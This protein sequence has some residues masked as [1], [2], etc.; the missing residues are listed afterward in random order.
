MNT[1]NLTLFTASNERRVT[2][3]SPVS[4]Y[5]AGRRWRKSSY[6]IEIQSLRTGKWISDRLK[7]TQY[8]QAVWE[9]LVQRQKQVLG[10]A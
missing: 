4:G 7:N 6:R 10:V 8:H 3:N 2:F 1:M 9:A 5:V